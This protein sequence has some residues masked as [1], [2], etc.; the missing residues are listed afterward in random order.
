MIKS[1]FVSTMISVLSEYDRRVGVAR[2]SRGDQLT[3]DQQQ[4]SWT[5]CTEAEEHSPSIYHPTPHTYI[6]RLYAQGLCPWQVLLR[7][8]HL[9][10]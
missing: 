6:P 8:N 7:Q 10:G 4:H 3:P 1:L 9:L 2:G 5:C